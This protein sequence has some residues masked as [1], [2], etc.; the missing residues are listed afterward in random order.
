MSLDHVVGHRV[1]EV[2]FGTGELLI[3]MASRELDA[4][5]LE[6]SLAMHRVSA[7]KIARRGIEVPRI[8]GIVQSMPFAD[9]QFDCIV[10]TFPAGYILEP[11]TWQEVARLLC[12]P[13]PS[14]GT[15]G[16]RF[17]VVGMVV[18]QDGWLWRRAVRFLFGSGGESAVDRFER[19]A[20]A[21]GLQVE[22][23]DWEDRGWHVPV[24]I[25]KRGV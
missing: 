24:I 4:V 16:G 20:T 1:L 14:V 19:H 17:V 5:G 15:E 23:T 13:D 22:V 10:S 11:E 8:Y 21:S 3:E 6:L 7:R 18:W 2:G 12:P 9:G 25:A